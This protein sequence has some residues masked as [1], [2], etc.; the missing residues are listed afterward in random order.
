VSAP[1]QN[2]AAAVR[3]VTPGAVEQF[4]IP[5]GTPSVV[6]TFAANAN[7]VQSQAAQQQVAQQV[8]RQR[9]GAVNLEPQQD[10]ASVEITIP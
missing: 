10:F 8:S 6:V 2:A 1:Q 4:P 7:A 5:E 9:A 3:R